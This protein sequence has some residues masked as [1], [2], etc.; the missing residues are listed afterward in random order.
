[1]T[2]DELTHYLALQA[3]VDSAKLLLT[4]WKEGSQAEH[5]GSGLHTDTEAWLW[6]ANQPR[7]RV[8]ELSNGEAQ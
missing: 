2:D 7:P 5:M 4:Q 3:L 6:W 8:R 1:M